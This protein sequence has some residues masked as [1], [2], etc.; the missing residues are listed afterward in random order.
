MASIPAPGVVEVVQTFDIF[1]SNCSNV[2]HV[3]VAAD[4]VDATD[5]ELILDTFVAWETQDGAGTRSSECITTSFTAT[6]LSSLQGSRQFRPVNIAGSVEFAPGPLS[7]TFA[8]KLGGGTRGRGRAGRVYWVGLPENLA[9]P[10]HIAPQI[11][12]GLVNA[13]T[14]LNTALTQA[15]GFQLCILHKVE[16]GVEL[17]PMQAEPLVQVSYTDLFLDV[18]KNRLPGHKRKKKQAVT[19]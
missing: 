10:S 11:A 16:N 13:V 3:L 18:Q 19:P 12:D 2:Y 4:P 15:G 1:G 6:D 9:S 14:A 5:V 8:V 7:T 17:N